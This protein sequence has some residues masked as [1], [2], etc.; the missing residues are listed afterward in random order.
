MVINFVYGCNHKSEK[1]AN[2]IGFVYGPGIRVHG[3]VHDQVHGRTVRGRVHVH[4][5]PCTRVHDRLHRRVH[6]PCL[7]PCTGRAHVHDRVQAVR[8]DVYG[9]HGRLCTRPCMYAARLHGMSV[10]S[11]R[12][13]TGRVHGPCRGHVHVRD[14]VQG[15]IHGSLRAVYT[16]VTTPCTGRLHLCTVVY[17]H[18]SCSRPCMY[19]GRVHSHVCTRPVHMA[20]YV[21][22]LC[23]WP[24]HSRVHGPCTGVHGPY[25]AVKTRAHGRVCIRTTCVHCQYTAVYTAVYMCTRPIHGCVHICTA[26]YAAVYVHRRIYGLCRRPCTR[27]CRSRVRRRLCTRTMSMAVYT[28]V[29]TADGRV[30]LHIVCTVRIR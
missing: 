1:H 27:S 3:R 16:A 25:M 23:T 30:R 29:R 2:S 26:V 5:G 13:S 11:T 7:W 6:G 22:G 10:P 8:T 21:Y 14:C 19:T 9:T 28:T 15:R 12:A 20:L 4:T 24:V 18:G 17:V